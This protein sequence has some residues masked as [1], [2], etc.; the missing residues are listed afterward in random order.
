MAENYSLVLELEN[1]QKFLDQANDIDT[2]IDKV[3]KSLDGLAGKF[4]KLDFGA[5]KFDTKSLEGLANIDLKGK[6]QSIAAIAKQYAVLGESVRTI[7]AGKITEVNKA[8]S[9]GAKKETIEGKADALSKLIVEL[10]KL[11]K[12][13]LITLPTIM[14]DLFESLRATSGFDSQKLTDVQK[15]RLVN[16]LKA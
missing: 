9:S 4:N 12:V 15:Q 10:K 8:L 5:I 7:D 14:R 3:G 16:L 11:E 2:V 13:N 1:Y 6:S